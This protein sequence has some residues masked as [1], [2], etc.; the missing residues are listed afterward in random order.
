[1]AYWQGNYEKA[2]SLYQEAIE[3]SERVGSQLIN[4][5]SRVWMAYTILRKGDLVQSRNVF[6]KCIKEMQQMSAVMAAVFGLEGIASLNVVEGKWEIATRL[7]SFA[8]QK[9]LELND[10][11]PPLE[12]SS[13]KRDLA[14]IHSKLD[15]IKFENIQSEGRAMT[16]EQAIAYALQELQ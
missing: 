13:I 11:R 2:Y 7:F 5:W 15:K 1:M 4:L 9:R 12:E 8:D 14:I 10:R 3:L 6:E 16:M